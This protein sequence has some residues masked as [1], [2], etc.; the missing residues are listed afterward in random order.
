M[1]NI[2]ANHQVSVEWKLWDS[3]GKERSN[4]FELK[5]ISQAINL[6]KRIDIW[7]INKKSKIKDFRLETEK[8]TRDLS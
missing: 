5:L 4:W 2:T 8:R 7:D 6:G 3:Y 1:G